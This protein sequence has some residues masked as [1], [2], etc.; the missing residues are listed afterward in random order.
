[1]K[2][3]FIY[4]FTN[5]DSLIDNILKKYKMEEIIKNPYSLIEFINLDE[6]DKVITNDCIYRRTWSPKSETLGQFM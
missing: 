3:S 1:M 6:I 2:N 5:N 4:K